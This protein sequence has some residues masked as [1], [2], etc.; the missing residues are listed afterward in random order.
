MVETP[1]P[2]QAF[3]HGPEGN[4]AGNMAGSGARG[5]KAKAARPDNSTTVEGRDLLAHV[6]AEAERL[7][8]ACKEDP[9]VADALLKRIGAPQPKRPR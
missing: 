8:E 5:A 3:Q 6:R 1:R 4:T 2:L 9:K 7:V